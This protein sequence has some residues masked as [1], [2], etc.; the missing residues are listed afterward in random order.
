MDMHMQLVLNAMLGRS[1]LSVIY[2]QEQCSHNIIMKYQSSI[3][4]G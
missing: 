3:N 2:H 4:V 1:P